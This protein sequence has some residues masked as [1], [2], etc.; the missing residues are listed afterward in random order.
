VGYSSYCVLIPGKGLKL[1][2][3]RLLAPTLPR[4]NFWARSLFCFLFDADFCSGGIF[5]DCEHFFFPFLE[6]LLFRSSFLSYF[7]SVPPSLF[8]NFECFL[9][10]SVFLGT[11]RS[12]SPPPPWTSIP[13]IYLLLVSPLPLHIRGPARFNF[14]LRSS[15]LVSS[16]PFRAETKHRTSTASRASWCVAF[17]SFFLKEPVQ[18]SSTGNRSLSSEQCPMLRFG[19]SCVALFLGEN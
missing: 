4:L 10:K 9:R 13:S 19:S 6:C 16:P 1:S 8:S 18:L 11:T 7:F 14:P 17:G 12:P 15:R 2:Y 5:V 3:C